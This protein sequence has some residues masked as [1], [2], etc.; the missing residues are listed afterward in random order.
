MKN[1]EEHFMDTYFENRYLHSKRGE[2]VTWE[3]FILTYF[4]NR[5]LHSNSGEQGT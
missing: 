1:E 5:Y 2:Q 3:H 4:E